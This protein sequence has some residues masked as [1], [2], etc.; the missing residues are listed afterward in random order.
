M[1]DTSVL[2]PHVNAALNGVACALLIA[3]RVQI[4]R[5]RIEAHRQA[6]LAA[7]AV[8][9]LFLASYVTYHF[10]APIFVF[11]GEG[12][13]RPFY[14][15]LLISHVL[16]AALALPMILAT[17]WLGLRRADARHRRLARW[18]WRVWM[19]VSVSGV[20]VYLLLYQIYR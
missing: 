7:L 12:L 8:S 1:L 6:M 3:G 10:T 13:I 20:L 4:S 11:R 15:A 9:A 16:L 19:Y 18:T 14:Y 2:L 5:K 17:T